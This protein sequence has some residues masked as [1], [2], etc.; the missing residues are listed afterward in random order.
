MQAAG[1]ASNPE[2]EIKAH[3][4]LLASYYWKARSHAAVHQYDAAD[5]WLD[6]AVGHAGSALALAAAEYPRHAGNAYLNLGATYDLKSY[7][8][9]TRG[10]LEGEKA[11]LQQA[12]EA[13]DRCLATAAANAGDKVLGE[14]A[15]ERC[16]P[17][18][19]A[20]AERLRELG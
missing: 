14:R 19:A 5:T 11:L 15:S 2:V 18:R 16:A 12:A 20:V 3:L 1:R 9:Y 10:D 4:G 13:F 17:A 6:T 7:L 8:R